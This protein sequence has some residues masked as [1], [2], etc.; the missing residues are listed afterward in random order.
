MQDNKVTTDIVACRKTKHCFKL[1]GV[2]LEPT[3]MLMENKD[4]FIGGGETT[5]TTMEWAFSGKKMLKNPR[6]M[7]RAQAEVRQVFGSRGY[8]EEMALEELKFLNTV[9]KE[10][11]RLHPHAP[12]LLPRECGETYEIDG[13]TIPVGTQVYVNAWAIGRD[14]NDW[15]EEEK[16]YP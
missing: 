5:S 11:L 4:M 10:T 12:L 6:V 13:Y 1:F 7:K 2:S 14:L 16:F 8:V 3:S 9:I 15:S